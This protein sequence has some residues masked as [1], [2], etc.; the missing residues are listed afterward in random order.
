MKITSTALGAKGAI[1]LAVVYV[2][3]FATPYS[4]LFFLMAAFLTVVG[5]VGAAATWRNMR[6][7]QATEISVAPAP[8]GSEHAFFLRFES[9]RRLHFGVEVLL[10]VENVGCQRCGYAIVVQGGMSWRGRI[11]GLERGLRRATALQLRSRHPF[12]VLQATRRI[13]LQDVEVTTTPR[14]MPQQAADSWAAG[15]AGAGALLS[16]G[17]ELIDGLRS[18]RPGD[19]LRDVHWKA[20]ARATKPLVKERSAEIAAQRELVIDRRADAAAFE[21]QLSRAATTLDI[22]ARAATPCALRM[23]SQDLD[24]VAGTDE[25]SF[26]RTMRWLAATNPLPRDSAPPPAGGP[27]ALHLSEFVGG[28]DG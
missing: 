18:W 11:R 9:R 25:A 24:I 28:A 7:L 21:E 23:L 10:E 6:G 16:A 12:G 3:F 19:P 26:A 14:R 8:A 17:D 15:L 22:A 1:F 27:Q 2:L 13:V 5:V 4:N 20:T